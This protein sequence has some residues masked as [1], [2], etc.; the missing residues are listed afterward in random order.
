M[1]NRLRR[2]DPVGRLLTDPE[3]A[4]PPSPRSPRPAT[5]LKTA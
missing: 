3:V 4:T 1:T 2:D 5:S